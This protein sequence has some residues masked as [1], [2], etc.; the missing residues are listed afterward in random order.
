MGNLMMIIE[1][2]P[3]QADEIA[4]YLTR[5]GVPVSKHLLAATAKEAFEQNPDDYRV[6]LIDVNLLDANGIDVA[7]QFAELSKDVKI[8]CA[9]SAHERMRDHREFLEQKQCHNVM[10]V[11][12]PIPLRML[13]S[14]YTS[15]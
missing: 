6:I 2:D 3:F 1:D 14:Y 9:T 8:I 10:L 12:K 13:Y 11:D 7:V 4:T 15:S 5:K